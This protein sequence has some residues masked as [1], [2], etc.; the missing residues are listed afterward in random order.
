MSVSPSAKGA[1]WLGQVAHALLRAALAPAV[2]RLLSTL[3]PAA[4]A[5]R[6]S[7]AAEKLE[8]TTPSGRGSESA[9]W[10]HNY[11]PSRDQRERCQHNILPQP[12]SAC[13]TSSPAPVC[14]RMR[15]VLAYAA[16]LRSRFS[17]ASG[18]A[19]L[20]GKRPRRCRLSAARK[21]GYK[22]RWLTPLTWPRSRNAF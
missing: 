19:G 10:V 5:A 14:E 12:Q 1:A 21:A 6:K 22:K 3:S 16:P 9:L 13:A 17:R 7:E 20:N 15:A 18:D 8:N 11:R 4:D 2:S